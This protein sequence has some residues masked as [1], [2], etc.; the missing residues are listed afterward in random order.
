MAGGVGGD[1]GGGVGGV[2][3]GRVDGGVGGGVGGDVGGGMGGG[4][5]LHLPPGLYSTTMTV[6]TITLALNPNCGQGLPLMV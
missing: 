6:S 2:L 5:G 3:S 4:V 1:V